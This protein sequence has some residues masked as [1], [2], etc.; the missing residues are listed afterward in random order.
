MISSHIMNDK[1]AP[2]T[3]TFIYGSYEGDIIFY[4]PMISLA[5]LQS[6][7][8]VCFPLKL[9]EAWEV[10]GAYP[11][12]YCIRYLED[13]GEYTVSLEGFVRREGAE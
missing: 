8:N 3:Q 2:F 11:T 10:G 9:P 5:Y 7:P 4:E 6:Q 12:E 13:E 1:P